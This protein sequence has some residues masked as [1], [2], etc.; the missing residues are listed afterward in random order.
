VRNAHPAL[1][2]GDFQTLLADDASQVYV[3]S[4]NFENEHIIVVLNNSKVEQR[5]VIPIPHAGAYKNLLDEQSRHQA[6]QGTLEIVMPG[7]D[8]TILQFLFA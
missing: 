3:F 6:L 5:V 1:Q 4:R 7:K 2:V 8:G